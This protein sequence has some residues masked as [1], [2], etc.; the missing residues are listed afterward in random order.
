MTKTSIWT[1]KTV[2]GNMIIYKDKRYKFVEWF[3]EETGFL[4]RS[5]IIENG[6]E[7]LVAPSKRSYPELIDI[8]IMG[9]CS[10]CE[11]GLCKAAGVD[12]YQNA[13][14]NKRPNMPFEVYESIIEQS[15]GK[16][17][18]IAL[19][20][21]GDPNKHERFGDMLEL[22]RRNHIVPNLT[23][24]GYDITDEEIRLIKKYCG[25]VAV[26]FYSRLC[27]DGHE[28]N[29]T[30]IQAIQRLINAG[31][32]TNIH[33][34][35][36]KDT[37]DEIVYRLEHNIFPQGIN[38]CVFLL[39]KP[40]GQGNPQK[41]LHI[42]DAIYQKFINLATSKRFDFKIGFDSCQTPALKAYGNMVAEE[43]LEYCESARFSMYIDCENQAYPC[44]FGWNEDQYRVDLNSNT[45]LDAW[46]SEQFESFLS[47]QK[48]Q[49]L[50]CDQSECRNCGL[51]LSV[52]MCPKSL[53]G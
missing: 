51:N 35:V 46:N 31:C 2:H 16:T 47:K 33:Y 37:I 8:G 49:C 14:K 27:S 34:V 39:Y 18:Q 29:D 11:K 26:S 36:S 13:S 1:E 23:T 15:T 43:S 9:T 17:F 32:I 4:M 50:L 6:Q 48:K 38:A 30:T 45:I 40:A 44:S 41:M 10:A 22:A 28:S 53:I 5:N 12:C 19:G 3:N 7:T 25:A 52:D 24:S 21:A 20:G 42:N